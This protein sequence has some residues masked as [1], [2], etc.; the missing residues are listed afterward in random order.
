MY[1]IYIYLY[2]YIYYTFIYIPLHTHHS[3]FSL[4]PG[5]PPALAVTGSLRRSGTRCQR[6]RPREAASFPIFC[7]PGEENPLESPLERSENP[8][9]FRRDLGD[10]PGKSWKKFWDTWNWGYRWL[11]PTFYDLSRGLV[12]SGRSKWLKAPEYRNGSCWVESSSTRSI[13]RGNS[14]SVDPPNNPLPLWGKPPFGERHLLTTVS[15]PRCPGRKLF[16]VGGQR[17]WYASAPSPE[18]T[19]NQGGKQC[20]C[21]LSCLVHRI[22]LKPVEVI[23]CIYSIA[24][25]FKANLSS[26]RGNPPS[27]PNLSSVNI[28]KII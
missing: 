7:R 8:W 10:G 2:I 16:R 26:H 13:Y 24:I 27:K 19:E 5:L 25:Q 28:S 4:N 17:G 20:L 6:L 22:Q 12:T 3:T 9:L 15:E 18:T 14:G 21:S 11:Q 1:T 23:S